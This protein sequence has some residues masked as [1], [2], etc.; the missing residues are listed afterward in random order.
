MK[1]LQ[2]QAGR[3]NL[4]M[5]HL[6]MSQWIE[7]RGVCDKVGA[8]SLPYFG[9]KE[10][11][12][13]AKMKMSDDWDILNRWEA[14]MQQR[15]KWHYRG[16]YKTENESWNMLTLRPLRR[17]RMLP[18]PGSAEVQI[19]QYWNGSHLVPIYEWYLIKTMF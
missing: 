2:I 3:L 12:S 13:G 11:R 9:V 14:A 10:E 18:K 15:K 8:I 17:T 7:A 6:K 19:L 1:W 4:A 5:C 16:E